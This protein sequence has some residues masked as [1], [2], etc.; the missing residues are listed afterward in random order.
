MLTGTPMA[1]RHLSSPFTCQELPKFLYSNWQ[2]YK[3]SQALQQRK[4]ELSPSEIWQGFRNLTRKKMWTWIS[5]HVLS[6]ISH[7]EIPAVWVVQRILHWPPLR[8]ACWED[9]IFKPFLTDTDTELWIQDLEMFLQH[10]RCDN[11]DNVQDWDWTN[12]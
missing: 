7:S 11:T 3:F 1:C 6:Q 12:T 5:I 10:V 2:V 8:I 9:I 4:L